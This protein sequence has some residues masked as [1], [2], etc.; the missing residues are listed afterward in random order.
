[1]NEIHHN[2]LHVLSHALWQKDL[3]L[4][5]S[6]EEWEAL[7]KEAEKQ[8]VLSL[9]LQ[10]GASIRT[11]VSSAF[12]RKWR[13]IV[14][15]TVASNFFL[16]G[17]QDQ[18]LSELK[19]E[20]IPCVI[21]KGTS[22]AICYSNP[23]MRALGDIDLL[24][25]PE[26]KENAI[27]ILERLGYT[28]PAESF[29]HPYHIDFYGN[30]VVV[31]LHFAASTYPENAGGRK[32]K[33]IMEGCWGQI[34]YES[35]HEHAFPCLGDAHQALSLLMHM[36]RHM[37]SGCIGLR[38][39]CDWAAFMSKVSADSYRKNI[40][41]LLEQCGL[42]KFACVLTQVCVRYLE[43]TL[44]HTAR[45]NFGDEHTTVTMIREI[46]RAGNINN[47][48]NTDDISSFFVDRSGEKSSVVVFV[49][50]LNAI[51][52]RRY[53]IARLIPLVLPAF[54]IYIPFKYWVR[55]LCGV[56]K[57]KSLFKTVEQ[58]RFR[59]SLYRELKLYETS[60]K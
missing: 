57:K 21:L 27:L 40:L 48:N 7:L 56:R 5:L 13:N 26:Y 38:Q 35:I 53:K 43:L 8:G 49:S 54:W 59:K 18:L 45:F 36:E 12:W 19:R 41:P 33:S 2:L 16:I 30:G 58:T 42:D 17:T 52:K 25:K 11:Q 51:A 37:T 1:M 60:A 20:K 31:E 15:S 46:L 32:A 28:A 4:V 55:S 50:K 9:V 39:L 29:V 3:N 47:Q 34:K 23:G 24:V 10:G 14:V 44:N 22:A 6:E